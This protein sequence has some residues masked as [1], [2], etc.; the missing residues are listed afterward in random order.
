MTLELT[1]TP[2]AEHVMT[3]KEE[4]NTWQ[5]KAIVVTRG[6]QTLIG[7]ICIYLAGRYAKNGRCILGPANI[8]EDGLT[9]V[10]MRN[11]HGEIGQV[12]LGFITDIRDDFRRLADHLKVDDAE[13]IELFH[14]LRK[15]IDVDLRPD[16]AKG[17]SVH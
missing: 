14:E 11:Q 2:P 13:R 9:W 3:A 17:P 10:M 4:Q 6:N 1:T 7:T 15:F 5:Y 16:D 12:C 8:D